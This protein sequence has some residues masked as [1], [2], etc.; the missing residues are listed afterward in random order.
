MDI[1][2]RKKSEEEKEHHIIAERVAERFIKDAV[3]ARRDVNHALAGVQHVVMVVNA[4]TPYEPSSSE[5]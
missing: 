3:D 1:I 5:D 2:E 4:L